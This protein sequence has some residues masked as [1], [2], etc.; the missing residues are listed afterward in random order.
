[1]YSVSTLRLSSFFSFFLTQRD[2]QLCCPPALPAESR[3]VELWRAGPGISRL[4]GV[5]GVCSTMSSAKLRSLAKLIL[6]SSLTLCWPISTPSNSLSSVLSRSTTVLVR[7]WEEQEA[8]I[9]ARLTVSGMLRSYLAFYSRYEYYLRGR[10]AIVIPRKTA[11]T[12]KTSWGELRF[13]SPTYCCVLYRH[14]H[15]NALNSIVSD[16]WKASLQHRPLLPFWQGKTRQDKRPTTHMPGLVVTLQQAISVCR[17]THGHFALR[18]VNLLY[19]AP[20]LVCLVAT[21]TACD[22]R[23]AASTASAVPTADTTGELLCGRT[24]HGSTAE[25]IHCR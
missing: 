20:R 9:K 10:R 4:A 23:S 5:E 8:K 24:Q 6:A 25:L 3:Q 21:D 14:C 11:A 17:D 16:Y 1:M 7:T 18:P 19:A 22:Y 13:Q 15:G 2:N 12:F